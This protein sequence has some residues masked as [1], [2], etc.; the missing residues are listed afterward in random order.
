MSGWPRRAAEA[1]SGQGGVPTG[2]IWG[3]AAAGADTALGSNQRQAAR[4]A[5]PGAKRGGQPGGW[6][7]RHML[8]A[9]SSPL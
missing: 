8:D 7:A 4:G 9:R 5:A 2:F 3:L 6:V 1:T